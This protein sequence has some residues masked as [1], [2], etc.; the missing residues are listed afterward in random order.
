MTNIFIFVLLYVFLGLIVWGSL[1]ISKMF[2][3]TN[4]LIITFLWPWYIYL[5]F[6][7]YKQ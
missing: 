1:S 2:T 3:K 5:T 6:K 7:K 4:P